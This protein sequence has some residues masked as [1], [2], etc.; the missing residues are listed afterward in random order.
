MKKLLKIYSL[1]AVLVLLVGMLFIVIPWQNFYRRDLTVIATFA[2]NGGVWGL[3]LF[4]ELT[5]RAYSLIIIH[6]LFC[7]LFFFCIAFMQYMH[8]LFP[9]IG[10]RSDALILQ[11]NLIL[12]IWT[13]FVWMG[14]KFA[15]PKKTFSSSIPNVI[16]IPLWLIVGL[17]TFTVIN[18]IYRVTSIGFSSLLSRATAAVSYGGNSSAVGLLLGNSLRSF[19]FFAVVFALIYYRQNQKK[20]IFTVISFTCLLISYSPTATARFSAAATYGGLFIIMFPSLRKNRVFVLTLLTGFLVI[21][22]F[23]NVFRNTSFLDVNMFSAIQ[24]VLKHLS[25]DWLAGDYDAYAMLTLTVEHMQQYGITWGMQFLGVLLFWF[26]RAWWITKPIGTGAFIGTQLGWQFTNVSAPLPAEGLINFGM[27]YLLFAI[28]LGWIMGK[29][30]KQYWNG[31]DTVGTNMRPYDLLYPAIIMLFFFMNRGD[32]L[33]ST[34]F[35]M[36]YVGVWFV[37]VSCCKT[38]KLN[39]VRN[40]TCKN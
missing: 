3:L 18:T 17:T 40:G 7:F 15:I 19:A 37:L 10:Q 21:L 38:Y 32:L 25:D 35:T 33:S 9:W 5:K 31:L 34:A 8:G 26:P 22:P 13:A 16:R 20:L 2:L 28:V 23:F 12:F 1:I 30:D 24:H 4:S 29:L 39:L 27:G 11:T 14:Y 6:W 36:A